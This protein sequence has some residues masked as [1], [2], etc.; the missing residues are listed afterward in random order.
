MMRHSQH[1]GEFKKLILEFIELHNDEEAKTY[2]WPASP[3][4]LIAARRQEEYP[5]ES[6]HLIL[7]EILMPNAAVRLLRTLAINRNRNAEG[8]QALSRLA[9]AA[10]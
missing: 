4:R 1:H 3:I 8:S 2:S 7:A 6:C 9:L 5:T 10:V